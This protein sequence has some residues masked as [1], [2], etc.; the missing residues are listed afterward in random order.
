MGKEL[1]GETGNEVGRAFDKVSVEGD[2][3]GVLYGIGRMEGSFSQ[4]A[5]KEWERKGALY[6]S[7]QKGPTRDDMFRGIAA[8]MAIDGEMRR[9]R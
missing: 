1:R 4:G 7:T 8:R 9:G 3:G 5:E 6:S 2:V